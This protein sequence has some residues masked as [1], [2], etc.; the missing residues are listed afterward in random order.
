L[1]RKVLKCSDDYSKKIVKSL[2]SYGF[3]F[4]INDFEIGLNS[5]K[6]LQEIKLNKINI[7][8]NLTKELEKSN[9]LKLILKS[10]IDIAHTLDLTI[11]AKG[12]DNKKRLDILSSLGCDL[13]QGGY[14]YKPQSL[15][16]FKKIFL[17][18]TKL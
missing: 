8:V 2:G 18:Y 5:L 9:K 14:F 16:S 10:I 6:T 15:K 7:D 4:S 17:K 12:V 1:N 3:L 13:A 11:L